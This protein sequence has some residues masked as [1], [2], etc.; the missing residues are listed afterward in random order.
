VNPEEIQ[1]NFADSADFQAK[2]ARLFPTQY[3]KVQKLRQD[4]KIH[5]FELSNITKNVEL[6]ASSTKQNLRRSIRKLQLREKY[7]NSDRLTPETDVK[8]WK[9]E[10]KSQIYDLTYSMEKCSNIVKELEKLQEDCART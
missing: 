7:E 4:L 5:H 6:L 1:K 10:I 8:I 3:D 2:I 9:Y